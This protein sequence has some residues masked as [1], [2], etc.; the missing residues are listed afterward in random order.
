METQELDNLKMK[1]MK[2]VADAQVLL[3][4]MKAEMIKLK[5]D[6][7]IFF[8]LR[9]DEVLE[10]IEQVLK[11]SENLVNQTTSNYQLVH[12]FVETLKSFADYLKDGQTQLGEVIEDFKKEAE[13]ILQD[14]KSREEKL[15]QHE[16]QMISDRTFIKSE[17]GK[18]NLAKEELRRDQG[19]L[20]DGEETLKRSIQRLKEK[21]I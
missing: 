19:K 15:Q 13:R 14:F 16:R 18:I 8:K 4:S 17:I 5:S 11:D 12:E 20:R 6:K 9:E 3:S 10:R 2:E 7:D 1:T 21:R